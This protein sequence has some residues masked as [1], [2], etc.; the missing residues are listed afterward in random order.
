[1]YGPLRP[2]YLVVSEEDGGAD[3]VKEDAVRTPAE[4]VAKRI[5]WTFGSRKTATER[6]V[7]LHLKDTIIY[8]VKSFA[9]RQLVDQSTIILAT[10]YFLFLKLP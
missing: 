4:L 10:H 7:G 2:L 3:G 8:I 9:A 1:M 6:A 5:V